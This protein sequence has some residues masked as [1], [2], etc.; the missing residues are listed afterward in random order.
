M[1][2]HTVAIYGLGLIGGSIAKA[3]KKMTPGVV[4]IGVG[5]NTEKLVT[6]LERGLIDYIADIDALPEDVDLLILATPPRHVLDT[7]SR[8]SKLSR[9]PPLV[10]DVASTKEQICTT[11]AHVHLS[12]VGTHPM[13]GKELSGVEHADE[14]LFLDKPWIYCPT[15]HTPSNAAPL[16]TTFIRSLGANPQIMT[17]AEHDRLVAWISHLP[18]TIATILMHTV[19]AQPEWDR[20]QQIASSGLL[21]T[22]RLASEHVDMKRDIL[23]T[24][25]DNILTTLEML[26]QEIEHVQTLIQDRKE[27]ELEA[28]LSAAK[29]A[30]DVLLTEKQPS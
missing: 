2:I 26:K 19:A 11:A 8:I 27:K 9:K 30:R 4:I 16:I 10:I 21:D 22:T 6:A 25:R 18:I 3:L 5:R 17:P 23:L 15:L 24:N 7:L 12:F 1:N 14:N 29:Q 28:Y 13:A 20:M